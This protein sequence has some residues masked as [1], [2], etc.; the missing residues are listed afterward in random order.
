MPPHEKATIEYY[1]EKRLKLLNLA[2]T[3]HYDDNK[4]QK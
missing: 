2:K 1:N 3:L 4:Y